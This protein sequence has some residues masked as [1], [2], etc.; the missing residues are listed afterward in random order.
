MPVNKINAKTECRCPCCYGP[1]SIIG[2]VVCVLALPLLLIWSLNTLFLISISYNLFTWFAALILVLV[3]SGRAMKFKMMSH[4]CT[5]C[6]GGKCGCV[7]DQ[8]K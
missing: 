3:L 8:K 6:C 7:T 5:G 1:W 2:M 4:G